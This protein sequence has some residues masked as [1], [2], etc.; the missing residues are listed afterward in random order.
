MIVF[1]SLAEEEWF[2]TTSDIDLAASGLQGGDCF[3]AVAA[4]QGLLREF[5]VDLVDLD[6]CPPALRETVLAEGVV[7]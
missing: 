4:L 5:E 3:A 6:R 2:G 7:L 1:G